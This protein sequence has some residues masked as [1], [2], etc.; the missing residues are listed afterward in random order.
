MAVTLQP[1][2]RKLV[3]KLLNDENKSNRYEVLSQLNSLPD[4]NQVERYLLE[5]VKT[6]TDRWKRTWAFSG[7]AELGL[8]DGLEIVLKHTLCPPE[9]DAWTRHFVLINAA[10]FKSFPRDKI[11]KATHDSEVLPRATAFRL[12]LT[13]GEDQYADALVNM[14][15]DITDPNGRWAAARI[16]RNR[17]ELKMNPLPDHIEGRF[18]SSLVQIA[19]D[20]N[21]Y[22]DTRWEAIQA[23]A[24]FQQ[25]GTVAAEI[26]KLMMDEKDPAV[27]RYYLEALTTLNQPNE[28][29][30]ALLKAIEDKDAQIRQDAASALA[31]MLTAEKSVKLIARVA[32][33]GEKD[34]A[35]LVDALR[36]INSELAAK[37]LRD[38]LSNPDPA[39][40]NRANQLL[41][42]LGG[43]AAAQI[44]MNERTKALD[45]YTDLLSD[46][47]RDAR[48]HFKE[49]M[50]QAKFS[51]WLS[52][53]MHTLIFCI[54][55]GLLISSLQQVLGGGLTTIKE[56]FGPGGTAVAALALL[57]S[58]FYRDPLRNVRESLN[59]LMQVDVV[60]L[61]YM[62]Q[63]NQ[64][65]ATFKHMFLDAKDFG[66]DQMHS[67]VGE[68]QA[69][70]KETLDEI[71]KHLKEKDESK[72]ESKKEPKDESKKEP[73]DE[74]KTE[75]KT[76]S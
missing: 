9:D 19:A 70:L 73:K 2:T 41:M 67:T 74:S 25:Q 52:L 1:E 30:Q 3:W 40:S 21:L 34:P 71:R 12:L 35:L 37:E 51:F 27:R 28:S 59:S 36:D 44:L 62:R 22:V 61:G 14:L 76:D 26:A 55:I 66:T 33:G 75:P 5:V 65:D 15:R 42:A 13:Y 64:I 57:L 47:D 23:L 56:W 39:V 7:L 4:K 54:G 69:A 38:A 50:Y 18:I 31:K 6:E 8:P 60:F 45:K 43:Q 17:K 29:Q 24:S 53:V 49:L 63:I 68:I 32:L 48:T 46:A 20:V 11:L 16:L 10:S 58:S 72:N